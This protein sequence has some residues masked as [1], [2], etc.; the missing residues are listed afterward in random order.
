MYN[1]KEVKEDIFK[2]HGKSKKDTGSAEGQ[3]ALFT[4]RINHLSGHLKTNRKDYNTERSLVNL[5]GKRRS[6]LDYLK[7]K[8]IERYRA[9]VIE[10]GLRK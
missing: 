4:H 6:L 7:N 2:K 9:I 10:L 8:D 1:S 3:I 5:V